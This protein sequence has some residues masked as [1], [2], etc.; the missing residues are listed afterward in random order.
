MY[1][2]Y[3]KIAIKE[4]LQM[5]KNDGFGNKKFSIQTVGSKPD[6][7]IGWGAVG[8]MVCVIF[9]IH[10]APADI[11]SFG[12]QKEYDVRSELGGGPYTVESNNIQTRVHAMNEIGVIMARQT[13]Y[14][15]GRHKLGL[16]QKDRGFL[17]INQ[18]TSI[19]SHGLNQKNSEGKTT[20]ER[21][22][23][24]SVK[25]GAIAETEANKFK[26]EHNL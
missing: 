22:M 15:E 26:N 1:Y 17:A 24:N 23:E 2:C 3:N 13:A 12:S 8:A 11:F 14:K 19:V 18:L 25:M 6:G 7:Q 9:A 20:F 4:D 10:L 16:D 5:N 21:G